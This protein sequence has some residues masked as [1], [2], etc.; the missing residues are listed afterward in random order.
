MMTETSI[1]MVFPAGTSSETKKGKRAISAQCR[2]HEEKYVNRN[3]QRGFG[4]I[5]NLSCI[6]APASWRTGEAS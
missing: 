1:L 6:L 5:Y 4:H 2:D 3:C